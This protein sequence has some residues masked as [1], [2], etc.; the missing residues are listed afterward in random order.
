M[1]VLASKKLVLITLVSTVG[2]VAALSRYHRPADPVAPTP[3]ARWSLKIAVTDDVS[4]ALVYL[5]VEKGF[6]K[7]KDLDVTLSRHP[8]GEKA[9]ASLLAGDVDMAAV[10]DFA[11]VRH[12]FSQDDV[13][14][15]SSL[16]YTEK[17]MRVITRSD[18][19]IRRP[20]DLEGKVV[21]VPLD[22]SA[23]HY[24]QV[25]LRTNGMALGSVRLVDTEPEAMPQ[26]LLD[27]KIDAF[28][29]T[30]PALGR[31]VGRLGDSA[32]VFDPPE[33]H[34]QFMA[35][36]VRKPNQ[37]EPELLKATLGALLQ[38]RRF[39]ESDRDLALLM[40]TR[41][42]G[43][44]RM[45]EVQRSWKEY[46][47]EL[48]LGLEFFNALEQGARWLLDTDPT[49]PAAPDFQSLVLDLDVRPAPPAA[50]PASPSPSATPVGPL[51]PPSP[52]DPAPAASASAPPPA[53]SPAVA[54]SASAPPPRVF[55]DAP[56]LPAFEP[57][58]PSPSPSGR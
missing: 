13:G 6:F 20:R 4:S 58:L 22:S 56:T 44:D 52:I 39:S 7:A 33:F 50:V 32:V 21:G 43:V 1:H 5:A 23:H 49:L 11:L 51:V 42:L 8:R 12:R 28:V 48:S 15:L 53:A 19:K 27:A 45:A 26:S 10:P 46:Q 24:L 31:A 41:Q 47:L 2:L 57:T 40:V 35:L 9:L 18:L 25:F 14:V 29:A 34:R 54:P 17:A 37:L 16:G 36:T 3:S 38:A 30:E 55:V